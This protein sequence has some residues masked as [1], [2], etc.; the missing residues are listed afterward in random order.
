MGWAEVEKSIPGRKDSSVKR[1]SPIISVIIITTPQGFLH[2][3]PITRD[4]PSFSSLSRTT[5]S[6][7]AQPKSES[8]MTLHHVSPQDSITVPFLGNVMERGRKTSL[9]AIRRW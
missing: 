3:L 2:V 5:H 9:T 6:S 4:V 8:P 7:K 1:V